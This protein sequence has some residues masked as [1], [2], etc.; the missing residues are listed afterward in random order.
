MEWLKTNQIKIEPPARCKKITGTR[1]AS[2]L[3]LDRWNTPFKTWC[4]ITRTYEEPFTENQ[5]TRAGKAIEPL[6]IAYLK[7]VYM[8]DIKTPE[9][10]YGKDHFK[11]TRGDFF[12][13]E[14]IFGGMWDALCYGDFDAV[15]EIKTTK[16]AE[17][18]TKGAPDYYALQAALYA[19]LR[20]VS[21]VIMV[22][23][24]LS[25]NDYEK[26]ESFIPSSANTVLESFRVMERFPAMEAHIARAERWW[27]KHVESGISPVFDE[28]ADAD[29]LKALRRNN[30]AA[31]EN[32]DL[33]ALLAEGEA[34][35]T[36]L[37]EVADSIAEKE[38]RLKAISDALKQHALQSFRD[39]DKQVTLAG[40][41]YDWTVS[42]SET[43][44]LDET[45][46]KK[47]GIF[48]KYTKPKVTY[49]M[50]IKKR[51]VILT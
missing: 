38:K 1:F 19:Y 9:D 17:D 31:D 49:T 47:E 29:I 4:A 27:K 28:K 45:A 20:G 48:E 42:K 13:N 33:A 26:P 30:I 35:K 2:V 16:R 10:V 23:S 32:T 46:L 7:K 14:P 37:D 40:A 21:D 34:L 15:I 11:K 51:E 50:R 25:D 5:Y 12:K 36:E 41:E 3:D 44:K 22:V 43:K 39:G 6:V 18:W 8:L 24:F